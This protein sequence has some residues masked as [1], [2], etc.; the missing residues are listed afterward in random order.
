MSLK[1][2]L[3]LKKKGL[4][5]QKISSLK[6]RERAQRSLFSFT[7]I[8]LTLFRN[9]LSQKIEEILAQKLEEPEFNDCFLLEI[10][11]ENRVIEIVLDADEGLVLGKCQRISRHVENWL[12]EY[13]AAGNKTELGD[14]YTIEVTS[15]GVMRSLA[16]PRQFPKHVGRTLEV[17]DTEGVQTEGELKSVDNQGITLFFETV[18]KEGKKKITEA[19]TR[20]IAFDKMKTAFVKIKF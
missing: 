2:N 12:D 16:L 15:P 6:K 20:S 18:R 9:M 14:D 19:V 1:R 10:S 11:I 7:Q 5:L 17:V 3:H 13:L 4:H 8:D